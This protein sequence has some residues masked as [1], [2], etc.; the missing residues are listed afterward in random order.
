ME[1]ESVL[2]EGRSSQWLNFGQY[3]WM[4][5]LG[6][7]ILVIAAN[8]EPWV[9]AALLLPIGRALWR[10]LVVRTHSYRITSQRIRVTWGVINQHVDE[11]ELY[12]VKDSLLMRPWWMRLFGLSSIQL[13]TSDRSMPQLLMPALENGDE[14]RE[15]LR[16]QVELQRDRKRVREMDFDDAG[17]EVD[18]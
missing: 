11:I 18:F 6:A 10:Y 16:R 12:R 17:G 5:F 13:E 2:W 15:I 14:I 1:E 8:T 9:Y 7:V 3:T 4:F